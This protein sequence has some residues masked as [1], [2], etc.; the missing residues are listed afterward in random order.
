MTNNKSSVPCFLPQ[1]LGDTQNKTNFDVMTPISCCVYENAHHV[2]SQ[3]SPKSNDLPSFFLCSWCPL[4]FGGS[5]AKEEDVQAIICCDANFQLKKIKDKD[6]QHR[7]EQNIGSKDPTF[8]SPRTVFLSNDFIQFWKDHVET[9]CPPKKASKKC[10]NH[11]GETV[12]IQCAPADAGDRREF[13]LPVLNST[14]N[15]CS[16]SFIAA[17][18]EHVMASMDYF[19][20]TGVMGILCCH[21]I[22]L[23]LINIQAVGEKHHYLFALITKFFEHIPDWWQVEILYDIGCQG[24]CTLKKY[25]IAPESHGA[26]PFSMHM[27]IN[28]PV[29]FGT[30]HANQSSGASQ[31]VKLVRGC[32]ASCD[33]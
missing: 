30:I 33:N 31:M 26:S 9:I 25:D 7:M 14:Y 5:H 1:H 2:L 17:N 15:S 12:D 8:M 28:I 11:E 24:D 13:G 4:C 27:A 29:N 21:D 6:H 16:E 20:N 10:R 32:G 18:G 19:A 23:F 22:P 3:Y